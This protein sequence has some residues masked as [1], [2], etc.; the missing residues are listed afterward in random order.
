MNL[1]APGIAFGI[2]V[3]AI[4]ALAA[5]G[6]TMQYGITNIFNLAFSETMILSGFVGYLV[7]AWGA[8]MWIAALVAAAFGAVFSTL[9]NQFLYRPFVRRGTPSFG[10]VIISLA[11][12]IIMVNVLA[13]VAGTG[14]FRYDIER[15]TA[16]RIGPSAFSNV[17]VMI[18]F[19][20]VV[21][22]V[23]MHLL[24]NRTELG[25]AMRATSADP[26]LARS[27]GIGTERVIAIA[28]LVSGALCGVA[29]V[30]FFLS[31]LGFS[32]TSGRTFVVLIIAAAVLGGV[33]DAYGAM[34]GALVIGIA[35]ELAAIWI[36]PGYKMAVALIILLGMLMFR[37]QGIRSEYAR[38][39]AAEL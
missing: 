25:K 5:V 9:L 13:A 1:L 23:G 6:F 7:N 21:V 29:G 37:P 8:S 34:L 14:V 33:G 26:V 38:V 31:T 30:A 28:W 24:L 20:A 19:C 2:V 15:T 35:T 27:C 16:F 17:Q 22:M 12:S 32:A 10:L 4:L 18:V 3:A 39:R 36:N 11:V